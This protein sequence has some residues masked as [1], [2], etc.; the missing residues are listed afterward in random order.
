VS[1]IIVN[2]SNYI[3]VL[4]VCALITPVLS[5]GVYQTVVI[6]LYVCSMWIIFCV[7][8]LLGAYM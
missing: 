3:R 6:R 5:C 8:L 2:I 4:F 7:H 1:L